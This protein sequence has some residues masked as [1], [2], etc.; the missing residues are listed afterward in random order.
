MV[1]GLHFQQYFSYIVKV[2]FWGVGGGVATHS[3]KTMKSFYIY[4]C[5]ECNLKTKVNTNS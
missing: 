5:L 1:M 3:N 4:I 2:V